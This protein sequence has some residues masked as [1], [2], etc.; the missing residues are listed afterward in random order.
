MKSKPAKQNDVSIVRPPAE[1]TIT[2]KGVTHKLTEAEAKEIHSKLGL[3]LDI[4][5]PMIEPVRRDP[6]PPGACFPQWLAPP[7]EPVRPWRD[8]NKI[9]C[10]TIP[11]P[12]VS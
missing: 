10:Q 4:F 6:L 7:L 5:P 3:A 12:Y 2:I 8:D 1:V 9:M 11:Q